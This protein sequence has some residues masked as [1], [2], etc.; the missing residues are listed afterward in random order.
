M[1]K[2]MT[3]CV[4]VL[5]IVFSLLVVL[6]QQLPAQTDKGI[7]LYNSWQYQE[8]EKVLRAA[9]KANPKDLQAQYYWGLSVLLFERYSEALDAFLKVKDDLAKAGKRPTAPDEY[10]LQ[11]AMAR[12]NLGLKK[13]NEAWKSLEAAEKEH[14]NDSD[15]H[16]YKGAYYLQQEKIQDAI[17]ELEKA[18][19]LDEDN[20]YAHYY[21][22]HAYLKSGNPARAV[23]MFKT[24][25]QLAP[26]APEATKA[27][28]L[29]DALC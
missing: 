18:M 2:G 6:P 20:A 7:K 3:S 15:V 16:A 12:A 14:P 11:I 8:A 21:A 17:A 24:F 1:N 13:Y 28:A 26:L 25:L 10:Q 23:D 29:V 22:G 4:L 27:K 19:N 5:S 9:L